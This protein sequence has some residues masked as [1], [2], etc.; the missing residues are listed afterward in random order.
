MAET[1]GQDF[2][3]WRPE[4]RQYAIAVI[5]QLP[6]DDKWVVTIHKLEEKRR[7]A[8]NRLIWF[9]NASVASQKTGHNADYV[10]GFSKLTMLQPM[11]LAWGGAAHRRGQFV[12][13][14]LDY[15]PTHEI[16]VGAAYDLVRTRK[17]TVKRFSEY[18]N[19]Y[20]QYWSEK[21]VIL[22]TSDDLYYEAMGM[23]R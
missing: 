12:Q 8:Q 20:Q 19:R 2:H 23:V 15:I 10:H 6:V 21:G 16:K 13:D 1:E 14:I 17:L 22:K 18:L 5:S 7:D 3:L 9:W 11:Y 4:S